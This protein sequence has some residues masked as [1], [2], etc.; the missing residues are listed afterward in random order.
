MRPR[1]QR[2]VQATELAVTRS[3]TRFNVD[4]SP[5][6]VEATTQ[7]RLSGQIAEEF[8]FGREIMGQMRD[9]R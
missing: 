7:D 9:E 3:S 6:K 1:L 4:W 2:R 8:G 5:S